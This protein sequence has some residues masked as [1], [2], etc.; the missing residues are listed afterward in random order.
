MMKDLQR[1]LWPKTNHQSRRRENAL[2]EQHKKRNE[3]LESIRKRRGGEEGSVV[4]EWS[5]GSERLEEVAGVC[6]SATLAQVHQNPHDDRMRNIAAR[7]VAGLWAS[8]LMSPEWLVEIPDDLAHSWYVMSRPEGQRCLVIASHGATMVRSRAG[9]L[10]ET[11]AS[12]LPSGGGAGDG[13]AMQEC[14]LDCIFCNGT[15]TFYVLGE[16]FGD[17]F[18]SFCLRIF[19]DCIVILLLVSVF[20]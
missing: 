1:H 10:K 9:R 16:F 17:A 18:F 14:V 5:G 7:S 12:G 11:F 20:S 8:Q 3:L 4:E 6:S 2:S 15:S 13:R 19:L